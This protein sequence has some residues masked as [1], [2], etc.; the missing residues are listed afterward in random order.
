M[1]T[2]YKTSADNIKSKLNKLQNEFIAE[3]ENAIND[4]KTTEGFNE[5]DA[6]RASTL[7]GQSSNSWSAGSGNSGSFGGSG[8]LRG[9]NKRCK[10]KYENVEI[11]EI[12]NWEYLLFN[13]L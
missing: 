9:N 5:A 3:M 4:V 10:Y 13:I 12:F 11:K 6:K 8:S 7:T 2:N 1:A